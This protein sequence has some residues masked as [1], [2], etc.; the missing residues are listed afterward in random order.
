MIWHSPVYEGSVQVCE[1]RQ[2]RAW[3]SEDVHWREEERK[4]I[5]ASSNMCVNDRVTDV[6]VKI[7]GV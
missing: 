2:N 7:Q 6:T 5:E 3:R 4:S 1:L